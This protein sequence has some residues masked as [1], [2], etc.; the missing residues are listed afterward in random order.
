MKFVI[1]LVVGLLGCGVAEAQTAQPVV[2]GH[3]TS[4]GCPSGTVTCFVQDGTVSGFG[5]LSATNASALLSTL[6]AG[7]NSAV[8]P[9]LPSVVVVI[10]SSAS[11]GVA[12]VCPLGGACTVATGIPLA[13]GARY[14]FYGPSTAMSVIAASTASVAAQW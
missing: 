8:W 11:A 6:T 10:N 7:P 12:Y 13:A 1:A 3:L 5:T 14:R 9:T 2:S 4:T